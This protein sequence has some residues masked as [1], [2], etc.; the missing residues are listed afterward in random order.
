MKPKKNI[1]IKNV[2]SLSSKEREFKSEV[3]RG[4]SE[5]SF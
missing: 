4:D 5:V 2:A 3:L 1:R